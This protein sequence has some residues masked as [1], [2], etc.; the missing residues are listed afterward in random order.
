MLAFVRVALIVESLH[1][2]TTVIKTLGRHSITSHEYI[3]NINLSWHYLFCLV[4]LLCAY[5]LKM[6]ISLF[7]ACK[8]ITFVVYEWFPA[9]M[10]T[11][12]LCQKNVTGPQN[13]DYR[14]LLAAMS[15]LGIKAGSFA[16]ALNHSLQSHLP[17]L[18]LDIYIHIKSTMQHWWI[19]LTSLHHQNR[20][21]CNENKLESLIGHTEQ[22]ANVY[23]LPKISKISGVKTVFFTAWRIQRWA[24]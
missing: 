11:C 12:A 10:Y 1:I 23:Q 14:Q 2:T 22:P 16:S 5:G 18:C 4:S 17:S 8:F 21:T 6:L 15:V 7:L 13:W 20:D 9:S 3:T 19:L 24:I